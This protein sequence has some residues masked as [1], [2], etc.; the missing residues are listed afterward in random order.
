MAQ[1]QVNINIAEVGFNGIDTVSSPIT[2]DSSFAAVADN[3]VIDRYGRIGARQAF[4][5]DTKT[6]P[7]PASIS[8][9]TTHKWVMHQIQ[10]GTLNDELKVL[11]T[12]EYQG[13]DAAGNYVDSSYAYLT[14]H[15]K[16]HIP[17]HY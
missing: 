6:L 1:Q 14:E 3:C 15:S 12:A 10:G 4:T 7:T 16:P 17:F 5:E 11:L 8:G 13:Y 9:A 2:Q